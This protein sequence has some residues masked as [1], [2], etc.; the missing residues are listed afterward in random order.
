MVLAMAKPP[1]MRIYHTPSGRKEPHNLQART[2]PLPYRP[3]NPEHDAEERRDVDAAR[4]SRDM[5]IAGAAL[6]ISY[7]KLTPE[8]VEVQK[9]FGFTSDNIKVRATFAT[10]FTDHGAR[11]RAE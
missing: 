1:S 8:E 6:E 10:T 7:I 11:R 3:Q 2:A 5:L 4:H 9:R